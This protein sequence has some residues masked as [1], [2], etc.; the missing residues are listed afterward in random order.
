[1]LRFK[2]LVS[3]LPLLAAAFLARV[4]LWPS[5]GPCIAVGDDIVEIAPAPFRADLRV[6][7]TDD[8]ARA[9]VRV[10]VA[11]NPEEADFAIVDDVDTAE[12]G[13]CGGTPVTRF[14]AVVGRSS[15]TDPV[16]YL[17]TDG[18]ADYRVFV[19]SKRYTVRDAAALIVGA[20]GAPAR[21]AA[22]SL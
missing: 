16:I 5:A 12:E 9:T 6:S 4:G 22:A 10:G 13:A 1:M 19:R 8:P 7:F 17:A 18:P 3:V 11:E 20:R 14:V 15:K 21:L 2:L